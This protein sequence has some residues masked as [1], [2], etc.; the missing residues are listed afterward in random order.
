MIARIIAGAVIAIIAL[1]ALI[2]MAWVAILL[3]PLLIIAGIILAF[4]ILFA[5]LS[6]KQ[7]GSRKA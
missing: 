1:F 7:N 2:K 6:E 5:K 3:L 4:V